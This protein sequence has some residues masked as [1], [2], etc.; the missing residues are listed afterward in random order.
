MSDEL[1]EA[2]L[3]ALAASFGGA[4]PEVVRYD[5][6]AQRARMSQTAHIL[7][8]DARG[9]QVTNDAHDGQATRLAVFA[10]WPSR[11]GK[12]RRIA[13]YCGAYQ[14]EVMFYRELAG[15]CPMRLPRVH[16]CGYEPATGEFVLLLED[17]VAARAGDDLSSSAAD[18]ERVLRTIATLHAQWMDDDRLNSIAWLPGPADSRVQRYTRLELDRI[19][20]ATAQGQFGR[21]DAKAVLS[22]LA[23]LSGQLG[24]FFLRSA[25][26]R[27]TLIHGDLHADQVLFP[28]GG[29]SVIVDWQL[30]Q[31]GNVGVDVARLITLSLSAQDRR[32]HEPG[33][34]AAYCQALVESG[35]PAYDPV[36]CLEDYRR[37][38]VWTAFVNATFCLSKAGETEPTETGDFH[39]AMFARIAAAAADHGLLQRPA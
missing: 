34:L 25:Q 21:D 17:L 14:R 33:L 10:K 19:S 13:R 39:D 30:V 26:G 23:P 32:Q 3:C 27:Q 5:G 11:H 18:V 37:G 20:R 28:D 6:A 16:F 7:I 38:I 36:T 15:T 35:A 24:D 4:T 1:P 22:L 29:D 31:R 2:V 8:R 9:A 12:V